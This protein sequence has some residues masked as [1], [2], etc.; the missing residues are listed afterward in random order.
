MKTLTIVRTLGPV[1][2][3]NLR[4]D[5]GLVWFPLLPLIMALVIRLGV[6]AVSQFVATHWAVNLTPY[7][8]LIMSSFVLLAPSV[9]GMVVGFLLLDERDD[10]VLTAH[11]V[12]PM[13]LGGYVLY[14]L[15]VPMLLGMGVTLLGYPL[16]GLVPIAVGDLLIVAAL[17]SFTAPLTAL[18]LASFAPNKVAGMALVK[19]LNMVSVLPLVAFFVPSTWQLVAGI[20]PSYWPLKLFWRA[21]EDQPYGIYLIIG[22]AINVLAVGLLVQRFNVVVHRS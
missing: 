19:L 6:P 15:S 22:L 16:A 3:K 10:Q 9:I 14:R 17:G 11:L 20:L 4:R 12:T 7:Y 21:V 2:F 13:S 18:F 1:D 8:P 5:R